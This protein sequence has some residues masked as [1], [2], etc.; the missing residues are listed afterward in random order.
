MSNQQEEPSYEERNAEEFLRL[1]KRI[2]RLCDGVVVAGN[3]KAG[4]DETSLMFY[5]H[6]TRAG[7]VGLH[8]AG[9]QFVLKQI[10]DNEE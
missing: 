7:A 10:M 4:N 9:K 8:E 6:G 5:K 3:V 2:S 1:C